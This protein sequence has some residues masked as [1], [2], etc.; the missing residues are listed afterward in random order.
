[1]DLYKV[2][3]NSEN[4]YHKIVFSQKINVY[5]ILHIS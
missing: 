3:K 5:D 2:K 1:M 4:F